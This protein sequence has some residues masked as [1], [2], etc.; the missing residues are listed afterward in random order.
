MWYP[1]ITRTQELDAELAKLAETPDDQLG[2]IDH[3]LVKTSANI[4]QLALN[5]LIPTSHLRDWIWIGSRFRLSAEER[6]SAWPLCKGALIFLSKNIQRA[7]TAIEQ[8]QTDFNWVADKTVSELVGLYGAKSYDQFMSP[9]ELDAVKVRLAELR[10]DTADLSRHERD[11]IAEYTAWLSDISSETY[12]PGIA[13]MVDGIKIHIDAPNPVHRSSAIA[14]LRYVLEKQDV[15][16]DGLGYLGLVDDIY[17]IEVT[18]RNLNHQNAFQPL[19]E[20]LRVEQPSLARIS[21]RHCRN[22]IRF[23]QYLQA[24]FG[25]SLIGDTGQSNRKCL[26]LPETSICGLIGAFL[27]AVHS[28]RTQIITRDE[29]VSFSPGDYMILSDASVVIAARYSGTLEHA[30]VSY[31]TVETRNGR[32]TITDLELASAAKSPTAHRTLSTDKDFSAWRKTHSP[33]PLRYLVGADFSFEAIRPEVLL[34]TRRNRL[35]EQ[36]PELLPMGSTIPALVGLKYVTSNGTESVFPGTPK[37]DPL[38]VA[39][40]DAATARDLILDPDDGIAPR[41]IVVDDGELARDLENLIAGAELPAEC[42]VI[43]FSPFHESEATRALIASDYSTWFLRKADVDPL[44]P[45]A[46]PASSSERGLLSR[47][48]ARQA[49]TSRTTIDMHDVQCEPIEFMFEYLRDL[50]R[51]ARKEADTDVELVAI[52]LSAFIRRFTA[53]PLEFDDMEREELSLALRRVVSRSGVLA[54]YSPEIRDLSHFAQRTLDFGIPPNPRHGVTRHL[55]ENVDAHRVAVLCQSAPMAAAAAAKAAEDP[56]LSRAAWISINQLRSMSP[57]DHLV[58]SGWIGRHAMRE[59]RNCGYA[60]HMELLLYGFEREWEAVSRKAGASWEKRLVARTRSQWSRLAA[61]VDVVARPAFLDVPTPPENEPYPSEEDS[62]GEEFL[63][64]RLI[65]T[66]RS[67]TSPAQGDD[68][69]QARLVVF[70]E[71]GAYIYLPPNGSVI[72]LSRALEALGGR[73]ESDLE[74]A[75]DMHAERFINCPV[76]DIRPGDLLAFPEE[77]NSDLLDIFANRIMENP[78]ETRS[79]AQLWRSA[80]HR[81]VESNNRSVRELQS[82]LAV[83]G[84]KRH[85]VTIRGWLYGGSIVAP[86]GYHEAIPIIAAVTEDVELNMQLEKAL[87]SVDLVYRARYRAARELLKQLVRQDIRVSEGTASVQVEG[88]RIQYSIQRVLNIDPPVQISRE[89]IGILS[90]V[91]GSS[92][93]VHSTV[94]AETPA[95]LPSTTSVRLKGE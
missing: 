71:P 35:D 50:R 62:S 44:P 49:L 39:C 27:A 36:V 46:A 3:F 19:V 76:P 87:S 23:D 16:P 38:I 5:H 9:A 4:R 84:L 17:A 95:S 53:A 63:N 89:L 91:T 92:D 77:R 69:A 75:S 29:S 52:A 13:Q 80:L 26:V 72:S 55:L 88:H 34:L 68:I 65:E 90:N 28:I 73:T 30:G 67:R 56:V 42:H 86:L 74:A 7:G 66:I 31:H 60:A 58:V 15:I 40:S 64:T 45:D 54:D 43:V 18:F 33:S 47:F 48:Q 59:I 93:P 51:E 32:R 70:E 12:L 94:A 1:P 24:V 81:F 78:L 14:C 25:L 82:L 85:R 6:S 37:A 10:R 8:F 61:R 83:R 2:E 21:F 79:L 57:I 22:V 20:W 41:Y 11:G